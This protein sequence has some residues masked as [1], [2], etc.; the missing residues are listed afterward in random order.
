MSQS[1]IDL[2]SLAP[3]KVL[4]FNDCAQAGASL[5]RAARKAGLPW[6]YLAPQAV[7]PLELKTSHASFGK[8]YWNRLRWVPFYLRR[9][10]AISKCDVVHVHYATAAPLLWQKGLPKRPYFLHLHGSDIRRQYF[11]P[12]FHDL[13]QAA[14]DRAAGVYF[15]NIDTLEQATSARKDAQYMPS[16]VEF[17]RL[18]P[19]YLDL[20]DANDGSELPRLERKQKVVVF[21]SRWDDDKGVE[22]QVEL[23][24]AIVRAFPQVRFEALD[25][26]PGASAAAA[27]GVHLRPKM[28]HK[29]Y[30]QWL[31]QADMGIGQANCVLAISE[32]EAMAIGLPLAAYGKRLPR[33]D[34]GT[35]P[36]VYD[37]SIAD[38]LAG[39]EHALADPQRAAQELQG[40][41][42][43]WDH[44][45]PEIYIPRLISA[46]RQVL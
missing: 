36:P 26:G 42:W 16:F 35:V 21:T 4:H 32:F 23:A 25:W 19:W 30:V 44:H 29:D 3:V 6:E 45:R 14:V 11:T 38:I 41:Q 7:R 46:Y 18:P 17:D 40:K 31:A 12:E 10:R 24:E 20:G 37:G 27:V 22:K 2:S 1:E 8:N 39:V 33:P 5:V 43:V 34:D 9:H 15:D 13:I 28:A